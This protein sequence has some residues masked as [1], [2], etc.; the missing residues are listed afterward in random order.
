M[1]WDVEGP[2][3]LAIITTSNSVDKDKT[4]VSSDKE[5]EKIVFSYYNPKDSRYLVLGNHRATPL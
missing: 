4:V 5:V 1:N 2:E 3:S